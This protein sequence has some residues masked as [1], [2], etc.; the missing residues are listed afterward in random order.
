MSL[1][2][3][4]SSQLYSLNFVS[5]KKSSSMA[6]GLL[7]SAAVIG[8][9]LVQMPFATPVFAGGTGG[10]GGRDCAGGTPGV[11]ATPGATA[12]VA[13]RAAAGGGVVGFS[14]VI[15]SVSWVMAWPTTRWHRHLTAVSRHRVTCTNAH[16]RH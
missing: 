9:T 1:S 6:L 4:Y 2:K 3:I 7:L 16:G 8:G 5:R 10:T 11:G 12:G 13:G 15:G 14:E